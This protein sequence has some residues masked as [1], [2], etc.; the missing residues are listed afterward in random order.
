MPVRSSPVICIVI[1]LVLTVFSG[2]TLLNRTEF[3]LLSQSVSDDNGF[4][5]LSVRFNTTGMITVKINGPIGVVYEETFFKGVHD[6][7]MH[8]DDYHQTPPGGVYIIRVFDENDIMLFENQMTFSE[9]SLSI[10]SVEL[11]WWDE[12]ESYSLVGA[13]VNAV[14]MGDLPIYPYGITVDVGPSEISGRSVPVVLLPNQ[15][16]TVDACL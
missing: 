15:G 14:N 9:S 6:A 12:G 8:L 5:S 13:E 2:C 4:A 10:N 3:H 16:A 1:V 7:I 11:F